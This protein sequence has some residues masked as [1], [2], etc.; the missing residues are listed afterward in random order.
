MRRM[1]TAEAA[2][3]AGVV[4]GE[5]TFRRDRRRA[6]QI[7]VVM[8]DRDIVERLRE[9]TGLGLIY[10][11][12]RR[13]A[14]YRQAW[15]WQVTR[16]NSVGL[17][18]SELAPFLLSRRRRMIGHLLLE[19]GT[20]IPE[21]MVLPSDSDE[22]WAWVAGI[23]EGEGWI[24]PRPGGSRKSPVL[25]VESTDRDVLDRLADLTKLGHILDVSRGKPQLESNVAVERHDGVWRHSRTLGHL[26][27]AGLPPR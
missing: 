27:P 8:T 22:A 5:G 24:G 19:H 3:V 25:S 14:H 20:E 15:E 17:L 23:V 11:R 26:A 21:Q 9:V 4:E 2:W 13:K 6:G 1:N 16:R 18:V 7:R 12:G 10:D